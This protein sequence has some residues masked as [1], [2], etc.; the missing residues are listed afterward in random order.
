VSVTLTPSDGETLDQVRAGVLRQPGLVGVSLRQALTDAYDAWL[1]QLFARLP[2]SAGAGGTDGLAVIA[3]GGLGRREPAPY[4]DIDLVIVHEGRRDIRTLADDFWYPIWDGGVGLDHSVRTPDEAVNVAKQDLKA[5]LGLLDLRHIAGDV[6]VSGSLRDRVYDV[7]RAT[8]P[9]R[10]DELRELTQLRWDAAGEGA[11]LLEPN[12]K[13]S[14]G[15][16]RDISTL[17]A[18]AAAQLIDVPV[19]VREARTVLLDIRGE[20]QRQTARSEDVL[21]QQ[22]QV[23]LAG[24]LGLAEADDV[25]R[26]VNIAARTIALALTSAW[27]RVAATRPPSRGLL[28]RLLGAFG[29]SGS[30]PAAPIRVGLAEGVVAQGGEVVLARDADPWADPLLA[31]RAAR[32][33]AEQDLPIAPFALE[34]LSTESAP[35]PAPWPAAAFAEFVSLLGAGDRAVAVLETLDQAGILG[36]LIPEWA[37]VR[38]KIQHNP[39]HRFTVDRHLIETAAQAAGLTRQVARPDLLLLGALLHDIGKGDPTGDHS[40]TGAAIAH[41]IANRMGLPYGDAATVTALVRHHLLLPDT[42]TRR[43]LDDPQTIATVAEAVDG[44]VELLDLLHALTVADAAATGPLVWSDW[45]AGLI[46]D[47]VRRTRLLV[48]GAKPP[49]APPLDER[50]RKLA[51]AGVLAVEVDGDEV[52]VAAPDSLGVLSRTAGVLALHS[53]DVRAASIRTHAGMAVNAFV[54]EPRFGQLPEATIVRQDLARALDGTLGLADRITAKERSYARGER[55]ARRPSSVHW[56]DDAATE[57]TV[58]ELRADDAIGLL[59]RVTSALERLG[60]DVRAARVSSLGG[61][62]VDAFYLTTRDGAVVPD[63][64]RP[65]IEDELMVVK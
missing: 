59:Y 35:M 63:A 41:R 20:L 1:R 29:S 31:L 15:G 46:V 22:E 23:N 11:F 17:A 30:T 47:L 10:V 58:L 50:R 55:P 42:A 9:K 21:R 49:D 65:G 40:V 43:D 27:R 53:L 44:S 2:I 60:L 5:V 57:A 52:L 62:V 18:L 19:A 8:A 16:L 3:V 48:S 24:P 14:S 26:Q 39:V 28:P 51:E 36:R 54:V 6:G 12:L 56:F 34:R 33:A 61:S 4:S 37:T 25:L 64:D 38:F 45:K 7:W 32:V 13:E